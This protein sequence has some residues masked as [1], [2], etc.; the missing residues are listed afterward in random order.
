[1][2]S[3]G[4]MG[5]ER[6]LEERSRRRRCVSLPNDGGMVPETLVEERLR[7]C[8]Y[9]REESCVGREERLRNVLGREREM[10]LVC[11]EH[12]MPCHEH[13][14]GLDGFHEE[15]MEEDALAEGSQEE[16][17]ERRACPSGEREVTS[18]VFVVVIM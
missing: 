11:G 14:F 5:P 2:P 3:S 16:R 6:E 12:V 8:K 17:R 7:S 9:E 13:G 1:M 18:K 10:T 15:R 4:G